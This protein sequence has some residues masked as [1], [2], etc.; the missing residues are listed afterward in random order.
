MHLHMHVHVR[1]PTHMQT[2]ILADTASNNEL[3]SL[4]N[5]VT[6]PSKYW[7]VSYIFPKVRT[8][9]TDRRDYEQLLLLHWQACSLSNNL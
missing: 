6:F 5:D 3:I 2:Y 8:R 9:K 1:V 7:L 4:P